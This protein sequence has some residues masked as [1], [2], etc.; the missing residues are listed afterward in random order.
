MED[1]GVADDGQN[2]VAR[3]TF[4]KVGAIGAAVVAASTAGS[5]IVP[6]LRRRGLWT[7]DGVLDAASI[8]ALALYLMMRSGGRRRP[9]P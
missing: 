1:K 2:Q 9:R 7:P 5:V 6:D 3:R 8:A 4:L